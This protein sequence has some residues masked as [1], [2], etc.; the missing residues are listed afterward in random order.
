MEGRYSGSTGS[1]PWH[2][3]LATEAL[4]YKFVEVASQS[5]EPGARGPALAF[6]N[7]LQGWESWSP[8]FIQRFH[9]VSDG[10]HH[11]RRPL[12]VLIFKRQSLCRPH[13]S[14]ATCPISGNRGARRYTVGTPVQTSNGCCR[15][16]GLS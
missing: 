8:R 5:D 7:S 3:C 4:C 12:N 10:N 13:V 6:S 11:Q 1:W 14:I 15:C 16:H 2:Q 9:D